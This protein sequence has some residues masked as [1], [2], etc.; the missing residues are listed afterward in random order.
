MD[1]GAS[2][3]AAEPRGSPRSS[4]G[5]LARSSARRASSPPATRSQTSCE[6]GARPRREAAVRR[7]VDRGDGER[8][9]LDHRL[10][11]RERARPSVDARQPLDRADH[12]PRRAG[13]GAEDEHVGRR[14]RVLR[15]PGRVDGVLGVGDG[16][17]RLGGRSPGGVVASVG[18]VRLG[19]AAAAG[20]GTQASA[21]GC[22]QRT[23]T[24]HAVSRQAR[25]Q[26]PP[27]VASMPPTCGRIGT[28]RGRGCGRRHS[29]PAA[30]DLRV[31]GRDDLVQ[32]A[33]HGVRRL[34]DHRGVGV[35]V[36]RE[37]RLGAA[38]SRPSAGWRR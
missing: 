31:D 33:D 23:A 18:G 22:E 2:V 17:P 28:D 6:L 20:G 27:A 25:P 34:G 12:R 7:R 26:P 38:S 13:F 5:S 35:G 4:S 3:G 1:R 36:D 29:A 30:P 16:A 21:A 19:I 32:V 10:A 9:V 11:Q 15:G 37:D 24:V 14:E 8:L